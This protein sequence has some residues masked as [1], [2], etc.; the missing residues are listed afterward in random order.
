MKTR[1]DVA[2]LMAAIFAD[3]QE[4]RE[5][6]QREYAHDEQNALANFERLAADL[7]ISREKALW[8]YTK[9]HLDGI[10][11]YI[12]GHQSQRENVRGRI[13]DVI[14]YLILFWAMV[15]DNDETGAINEARE[16]SD[17]NTEL[18]E[19]AVLTLVNAGYSVKKS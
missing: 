17:F 9:K 4:T 11:A 18:V 8:V 15:D 6:G 3:C 10:L 16:F 5:A 13:K 2:N 7:G 14:V 19:Q 12:N 1:A